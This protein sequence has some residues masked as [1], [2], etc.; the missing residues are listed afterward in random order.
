MAF[1]KIY[2]KCHHLIAAKALDMFYGMLYNYG[3]RK[4]DYY[5]VKANFTKHYGYFMYSNE[6]Q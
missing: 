1:K 6:T 2:K 4:V 3:V 5:E